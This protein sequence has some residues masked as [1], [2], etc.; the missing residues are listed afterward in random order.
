MKKLSFLLII[1]LLAC[2]QKESALKVTFHPE[3]EVS[4][5]KIAIKDINPDLPRDWSDYNFVTLEFRISTPQRFQV[6]FT[7]D[8]GYNDLRVM[9]YCPGQWNRLSI[10]LKFYTLEPG[11]NV[12]LAAT[13]N[14]PRATG[15]VN[16]GGKRGPLVGVDSIG[17]RMR[18][19][20]GEQT[21]E[22]RGIT[23]SVEDPGDEYFGDIPV[24]D[25][26]GQST[27]ADYP[28]KAHSLE[29]LQRDWKNEEETL[30]GKGDF[31]YGDFGGYKDHK[32]KGTGFFRT[33]LIDGR[34]WF[35]DPEGCLFLS[36]GVDCITPGR[37][38]VLKLYDKRPNMFGQVPPEDLFPTEVSRRSYGQ[39]NLYR[40]HGEDYKQK[41]VDLI[42]RR[43]DA[44]GVNTIGNWSSQDVMNAGKK[45]FAVTMGTAGVERDLMGLADVY[46]ESFQQD[47]EKA[48]RSS[49]EPYKGNPWVLGFFVGN[50][51]AWIGQE[52]RLADIILSGGERPIKTALESYLKD[53]GDS[54]ENRIGF[55]RETFK[56]YILAVSATQKKIDPDHLNLG[57]RFGSL[58]AVSEDVLKICGEAFDVLSFN[59]YALEPSQSMMTRALSITGKP[60]IIGEFHFGTIDRGL[61]PSLW[62]VNSQKERG[63]AYRYYTEQ[64]YSHPGLI[65]TAYFQWCDQDITG[66]NNDGEDYN[67]GLLDVTDRPY[68]EQVNAMIATA[69]VLYDV[70]CGQAAPYSQKVESAR[71]H[72]QIPDLWNE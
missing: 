15:W 20:I 54:Q 60:M 48:M 56:K 2:C 37:G 10:P 29:D 59:M 23:L 11:A 62:Q 22:I 30:G 38:G 19:P 42:F 69:K 7:T 70:H 41:S 17:I 40:R 67:C 61:A 21:F 16:L 24:V 34:W 33:E 5:A 52:A 12:D 32:V 36:V 27:W 66:R 39:W 51:P 43:M 64:A 13:F 55:I 26:F 50:E 58:D 57:Y 46:G 68:W 65:G 18:R 14:Q 4:G 1:L 71:G 53:N 72:E 63:M 44:W 8:S 25:E 31:G 35:V 47:L 3:H 28:E 45:A 49:L 6:G 9:S